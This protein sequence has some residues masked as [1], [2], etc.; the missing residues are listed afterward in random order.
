LL[1]DFYVNFPENI[2]IQFP[3]GFVA[4]AGTPLHPVNAKNMHLS[5]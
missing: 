3:N 5:R 4:L 2:D 1:K